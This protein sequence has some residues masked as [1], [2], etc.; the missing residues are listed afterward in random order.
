MMLKRNHCREIATSAE[1]G[2]LYF[3]T[4]NSLFLFILLLYAYKCR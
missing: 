1:S 3:A 4:Y 2:R